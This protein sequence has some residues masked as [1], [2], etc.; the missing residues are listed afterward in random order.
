MSLPTGS[1]LGHYEISALLGKGGMGEVYRARDSRLN[2]DVAIKVLPAALA[3]DPGRM[4]RFEREAQVLAALNHPNIAAIYGLESGALVME[5]VPGDTLAARVE[6][7]PIPVEEALAVA[8][9]IAEALEA[10]HEKGIIHRD[11]KPANVKI[12]P[13]GKVKVLDFGLAKAFDADAAS[14]SAGLSNSPTLTLEATRA[15]VILGTAGYMSPEQARG[16]PAD[17][18][19]DIWS[20]GVVL[21]E[22][23]TGRP[24]F[25]GETVSDTLAAVL[26]ADLDWARLPA[27]TPPRIRRLLARCLE[28]DPARRLHDIADAR[29]EIDSPEEAAP[30][31]SAP[32]PRAASRVLPWVL[33]ALLAIALA[34]IALRGTPPAAPRPVTRWSAP[35]PDAYLFPTVALSRDGTRLAYSGGSAQPRP[36]LRLLDQ[37]ETR[38]I[39]G[40]DSAFAP[41]FS[42]DGQWILYL[43]QN[44]LKKIP[45]T[46]G[47]SI[48]LADLAN[49]FGYTWGDDNNIVFNDGSDKGLKQVSAAGGPVKTLTTPDATRGEASH[50]WPHY[51]PGG[52]AIVFT[53]GTNGPWDQALIALLDLKTGGKRVLV[54]G[55]Y[56]GKYVPSGHLVY[57]R[58]TTL[59]AVPFDIARMELRGSEVPVVEG[60]SALPQVGFGDYDFAD[61]GLLVYSGGTAQRVDSTLEWADR[62]GVR[63]PVGAPPKVYNGVRLSPDGERAAV[64]IAGPDL[65]HSDIWIFDL[66][67]GTLTRLTFEG[68][69]T[70][71]A[72]TPDSRR[73]AFRSIIN[74][75]NGISW[76]PVDGSAKP[77]P[78]LAADS[79]AYPTS[80]SPDGRTLLFSQQETLSFKTH[81][82]MLPAPGG[83]GAAQASD[84]LRTEFS[85][86]G[87]QFSPDGKWVAYQSDESGQNQIY[88]RPFPG[89]GGKVQ[90]STEAGASAPR[91]SRNGKE[92]F[93]REAASGQFWV[94]DVQLGAAFH[95]GRPQ[96]LFKETG[97]FDIAPDGQRILLVKTPQTAPSGGRLDAV[98]NWF[99]ELKR[100]APKK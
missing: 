14:V 24:T 6:H 19:A 83:G 28:R 90:I 76:A 85:E 81:V 55:G 72:W 70:S 58:G 42:P 39:A 21:F 71:P 47:T 53:I 73:V 86:T 77:A 8:R 52:K 44:K 5:L 36:M 12:T 18:R 45:V 2:R 38:P 22:V 97:A 96:P 67:R 33:A 4:A 16:K 87:A 48:G 1:R 7:G 62:S 74:E 10:A 95:A 84:F 78:L 88:V 80:W 60:V 26:R 63:K 41:V 32:A 11:L 35:I 99:E 65:I 75:K 94:V 25:E 50:R 30:V 82:R 15:G 3:N 100:R 43:G 68:A 20:F 66:S 34:W 13:E 61:S 89:P 92:L 37:F 27:E 54:K 69:N 49:S 17:K 29:I 64:V 98:V 9:Q 51:V 56:S 93:Y 40:V 91:W 23:L 79:A 57:M 46:G 31:Q 59:F